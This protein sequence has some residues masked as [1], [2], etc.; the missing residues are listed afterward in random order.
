[1]RRLP[2]T[3][4]GRCEL[5]RT[6]PTTEFVPPESYMFDTPADVQAMRTEIDAFGEQFWSMPPAERQTR[7]RELAARAANDP[8]SQLRLGRIEPALDLRPTGPAFSGAQGVIV[9][10]LK[11][12]SLLPPPRRA[13]RRAEFLRE[14]RPPHSLWKRAA[15]LVRDARPDIAALDRTLMNR[16]MTL[17][18]SDASF[19][20]GTIPETFADSVAGAGWSFHLEIPDG[21]LAVAKRK[22]EKPSRSGTSRS[23]FWLI[24]MISLSFGRFCT[25]KDSPRFAPRDSAPYMPPI[26]KTIPMPKT[27][28]GKPE[29]TELDRELQR[30]MRDEKIIPDTSKLPPLK[31][32]GKGR[33]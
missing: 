1:L 19:A 5:L 15:D 11:E 31:P 32:P 8:P 23:A 30:W 27:P 18:T 24:L 10:A 6:L 22:R 17:G 33:P 7:W 13:V 25:I 9:L 14:L 3:P 26:P 28:S 4:E 2:D 20:R 16:L 29:K 21:A 12:I